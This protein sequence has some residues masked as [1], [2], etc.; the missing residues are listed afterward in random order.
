[1][2]SSHVVPELYFAMAYVA[3]GGLN[4]RW[5]RDEFCGPEKVEWE[6]MSQN[7]YNK[8]GEM[9]STIAPGSEKLIFLPHLSGRNTPNDPEMRGAFIG[10]TW[11]HRKPHLYR[12]ILESIGYE[13]ALYL[14]AVRKIAPAARPSEVV[15][16]G[17]GARSSVFQ[18]IKA[19]ILGLPY[20]GLNRDEFGTLGTAI[21]A[22]KS[23]GLFP[24]IAATAKAFV[25]PSPNIIAPDP[26]RH[27]IYEN[28]V[29]LYEELT[30]HSRPLF[31]ALACM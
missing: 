28:Y 25:T 8:L 13:Y 21:V 29:A 14:K 10:L 3:G 30:A 6:K 12:G 11:T 1:M 31:G 17:G 7:A 24:D 27:R 16:I 4:T 5:F 20:R 26:E 2:T 18:Q 23:V 22:G 15:N 19:D 9:A